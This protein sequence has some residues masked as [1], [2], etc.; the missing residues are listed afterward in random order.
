MAAARPRFLP[1]I[2]SQIFVTDFVT[3]FCRSF[4]SRFLSQIFV[5]DE[6]EE[7]RFLGAGYVVEE[8][9][10]NFTI[11]EIGDRKVLSGT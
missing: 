10:I 9:E 2:L 1:R 8:A 5:T 11:S 3:D 4:W 7:L 6:E